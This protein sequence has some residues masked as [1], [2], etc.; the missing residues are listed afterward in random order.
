MFDIFFFGCLLFIFIQYFYVPH[1]CQALLA[2]EDRALTKNS[3]MEFK[4]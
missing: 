4:V 3:F 2:T 1:R